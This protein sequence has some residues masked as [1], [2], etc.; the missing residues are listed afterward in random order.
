LLGRFENGDSLTFDWVRKLMHSTI[1]SPRIIELARELDSE[2]LQSS[3][4]S[5]Y[6]TDLGLRTSGDSLLLLCTRRLALKQGGDL[7]L[8]AARLAISPKPI[9][10]PRPMLVVKNKNQ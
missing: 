5:G 2:E 10:N 9:C 7:S 4:D 6:N 3:E 1:C 8:P